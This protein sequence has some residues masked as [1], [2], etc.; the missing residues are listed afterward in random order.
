MLMYRL[1]VHLRYS[2]KDQFNYFC[3]TYDSFIKNILQ[4]TEF[5]DII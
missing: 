2:S 1:I 4:T 5:A 3:Q